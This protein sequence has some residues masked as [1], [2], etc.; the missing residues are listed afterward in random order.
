MRQVIHELKITDRRN[1]AMI[2]TGFKAVFICYK[3]FH[4][5]EYPHHIWWVGFNSL[6]RYQKWIHVYI[7]LV[8]F[9]C[10]NIHTRQSQLAC[11]GL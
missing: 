11:H 1:T 2:V 7:H 5:S 8:S 6:W 9:T 3:N 10:I 4:I